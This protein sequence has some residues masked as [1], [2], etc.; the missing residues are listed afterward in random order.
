MVISR[1]D[2]NDK[3]EELTEYAER[4]GDTIEEGELTTEDG[5]AYGFRASRGNHSYVVHANP[6]DINEYFNITYPYNLVGDIARLEML[7]Q[8]NVDTLEDIDFAPQSDET[9]GVPFDID[10]GKQ[11]LIEIAQEN[12]EGQ[13]KL[14]EALIDKVS[15]PECSYSIQHENG[16]IMAV[17][18]TRRIFPYNTEFS[19][20]EYHRS[21]QTVISIGLP[22][23]NLLQRAHGVKDAAP[24]EGTKPETDQVDD[25]EKDLRYIG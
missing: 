8:N 3:L 25:D 23:R 5:L 21:V 9:S 20:S 12:P 6:Q 22:A 17:E 2:F 4:V 24:P 19:L 7:Q 15:S 11:K 13:S 16:V 1:E 10:I 14:R 18:L